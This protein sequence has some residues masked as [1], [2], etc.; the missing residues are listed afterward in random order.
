MKHFH[1]Y[2]EFLLCK[3]GEIFDKLPLENKQEVLEGLW[4]WYG[5]RCE[6][7]GEVSKHIPTTEWEQL[8]IKSSIKDILCTVYV[9]FKKELIVPYE[10]QHAGALIEKERIRINNHRYNI[11]YAQREIERAEDEI[12]RLK[13]L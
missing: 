4:D 7:C 1:S 3:D 12:K 8:Q 2:N 5:F 13:K 9:R 6:D 11:G 10:V